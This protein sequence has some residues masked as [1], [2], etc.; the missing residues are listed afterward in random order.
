MVENFA[1]S[2]Q[3][4]AYFFSETLKEGLEE[5]ELTRDGSLFT[6]SSDKGIN[7]GCLARLPHIY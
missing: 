3:Y 1:I 4:T 7:D 2:F 6:K 5:K